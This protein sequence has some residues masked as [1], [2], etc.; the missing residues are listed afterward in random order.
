[1]HS[2]L[3]CQI[4]EFITKISHPHVLKFQIQKTA[5]AMSASKQIVALSISILSQMITQNN[6]STKP[7]KWFKLEDVN[8][9]TITNEKSGTV[10]QYYTYTKTVV[11]AY[12]QMDQ[13]VSL[14]TSM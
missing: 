9:C 6:L 10:F 1:M 8:G 5:G 4:Y 7:A 3:K 2:I 14:K 13:Q 11:D 12:G